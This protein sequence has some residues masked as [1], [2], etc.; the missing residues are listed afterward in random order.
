M[1]GNKIP[2]KR[3]IQ[4]ELAGTVHGFAKTLKFHEKIQE[5]EIRIKIEYIL[6]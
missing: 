4:E 2:I 5:I 1:K 6:C 3:Y